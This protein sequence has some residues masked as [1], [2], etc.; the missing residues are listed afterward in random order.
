MGLDI[1]PW[2]IPK[3]WGCELSVLVLKLFFLVMSN[4][5]TDPNIEFGGG[6]SALALKDPCPVASALL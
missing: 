5:L 1:V 2:I 6:L 3:V 4:S